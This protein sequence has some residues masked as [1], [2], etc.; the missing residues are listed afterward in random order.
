MTEKNSTV[1]TTTVA[2]TIDALV[3]KGLVALDK[4]RQLTQEQVDYIVAKA[5]VAALDA[6]GEL[7]KHA[8]EET[9]RGVFEDKATKN[10]FACEH[11]VNNMRHQKTVGIIEEDDVT[12]LTLIA[13][14]VGVICGITP[15]TNPTSTAI[16]K[17]LISLKTRNPII[18][19][20]HPSA[21]ESS[22][23]AARIV[24][25]AA[26]AAGAPED[27]VQWI[28]TPSL[29][30]TNALMNHDGIATILATGGNAMVKAAYSCGKPALGVGAGNV[31]AYVEKSANI[32]Q[33]AHDIVMSKSFDN[34]MVCASEQAVIIDKEIYDE[35][36]SEFKSYHTYFVNKKEKALLEEFCFG[37]KANSKN[38]AGAKLNPNIVG[39]PAT[40]IAEQA[41][42]TV[43][44]GTNILAAECKEVSENEPLTR[45]KLSPVI[46]VLKAE[47]RE[48]GVEKARQM[49]EFNGLGHSA[50]IHTA[51]ADLAKEF[52]TRI[53]AIRVIW[54][55]PSTFGG[56]GDV[57]NA[58]LPSLTLGCGSYGRNSVGDNVSAVNLLNIKKVGRRRN[59]M[60]WFK[61]PSKTYFERDSIQYL[62]KCR[63]VERVMI[64]TDHAMVELGFLDRIIEQ[65][66]LRRN[67]VVYQIFADVEPDPDI[68]TVMKGTE[69]MRTFKPDTIIA[70]GGGSPMDA[71]KVMWL[72][73]EQPEVDFHDLVQ[74]FMD[75][76][77]RAFKFPELGKKTK[78]VAIPTTSGTG[79]EVTPFAVIS[80]KA[81]N[82]K[83]PI[84]DYSL[85]PTVAIVDPALV[86]TVPD[87]I[88][89]DTGMDV[90]THATE[91]YVSQMANDFTDGLALQAIKIV[92][93]NLEKSVKEADFE[94]R[95]KMHNASTMA[96]MAFANAFLGIS[97]SM[98]HKIGAQFHTVH[99]R[100]N[101]ILLPYVI[102]Y[103]GTRPAKTATW[104]KYN[105]YRADEK[106]QDIAKL[107]G[108]PAS[109]PE[110]GVESYAK[111]VYD[112]G[113]RLGIKMNFRDQGID[114]EE[115]KAH[116]RELAYLA[117][118]DQCS[119]ANPRLPMVEHMEEIMNDAYY[120]YA[121]RP[122]R[123]K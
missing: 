122:G 12:G 13:E 21:Q 97:H 76:R 10:L 111:A 42:F 31:P 23:H 35:F 80:D 26:I 69:L 51:D 88:A 22:A 3:Q 65:L 81:N 102:R 52:G 117:Y 79:S 77:K 103:N 38:C 60:Q 28:E 62:Q 107:L 25:D 82:R 114:E 74:K 63:D 40:W 101:A 96:G 108:L 73:Y 121:E 37:A 84:A 118:E 85:T 109:T 7:A 70:L 112:L 113:C 33:A 123:R 110:E 71:A 1:E 16:F 61:V 20:F 55:S 9:G 30:A 27:C 64:V 104:P 115:W 90:L 68:T 15:T 41:G 106:Y 32:R 100:T 86:L 91:A 98:A 5:S 89:A 93:E 75:I 4:M 34:G 119:P 24:R 72:F 53:R 105:Y 57:Y 83:Y 87:F 8:Y 54:N 50:A 67:K 94:S 116:T 78:F 99:G 18:F 39:K 56:I 43:P 29:E 17:S 120:G 45:E 46:A 48:D 92:F 59:N 95:E 44:E 14:P 11:V 66:D 58:F 6:H 47:S 2:A 19:A 36:V 49:V